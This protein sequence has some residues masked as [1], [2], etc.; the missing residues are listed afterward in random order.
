[1]RTRQHNACPLSTMEACKPRDGLSWLLVMSRHYTS[2]LTL[3]SRA[4]T[5][6]VVEVRR[7]LAW[8]PTLLPKVWRNCRDRARPSLYPR[9]QAR[10]SPGPRARVRRDP[11]PRG[12]ARRNLLGWARSGH[13][14][15]HNHFRWAKVDVF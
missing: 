12:R 8:E 5:S 3:G 4:A 13:N 7:G 9:G 14:Y 1:M 2:L 6:E 10:R 15:A 11:H